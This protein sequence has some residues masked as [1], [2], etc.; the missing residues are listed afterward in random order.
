MYSDIM[1][2]VPDADEQAELEERAAAEEA[3]AT[4]VTMRGL[5][6]AI[7]TGHPGDDAWVSTCGDDA[8]VGACDSAKAITHM[9]PQQKQQPQQQH[10][11]RGSAAA[12][13]PRGP[14][15]RACTATL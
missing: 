4:Q 13:P 5:A 7:A 14:R 2:A 11:R 6:H 3:K 15:I 8:W 12:A 10:Q 1:T 9:R